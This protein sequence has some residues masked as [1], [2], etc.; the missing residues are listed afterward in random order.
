MVEVQVKEGYHESLENSQWFVNNLKPNVKA[1]YHFMAADGSV[2]SVVKTIDR[3]GRV[4][5]TVIKHSPTGYI[6]KAVAFTPADSRALAELLL[7]LSE[8]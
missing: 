5:I 6:I 7:K 8:A 2:I 4:R 3:Y 1:G